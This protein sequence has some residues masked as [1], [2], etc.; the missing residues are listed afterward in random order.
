MDLLFTTLNGKT[1]GHGT[2]QDGEVTCVKMIP[3]Q[4]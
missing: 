1:I 3:C 2:V 4:N